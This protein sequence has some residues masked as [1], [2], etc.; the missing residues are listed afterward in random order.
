MPENQ[1]RVLGT[2]SPTGRSDTVRDE[3]SLLPKEISVIQVSVGIRSGTE[4][5]F[6]QVKGVYEQK[7]AELAAKSVDMIHMG[8]AP[9][10]MVHG[11]R[12]EEEFVKG[13]EERYKTPIY[14]AGRSQSAAFRA[15]GIQSFVG[16]T[17]FKESLNQIFANYF[18]QAGFEVQAMEGMDIPFG[19]AVQLSKEEICSF[20]K[21]AFLKH[22]GKADGIYMLGSG[23]KV[24]EVAPVLEAELQVPVVHAQAVKIWSVLKHF[25][26]HRPIA[27]YGRLLKELPE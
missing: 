5:E 19:T 6:R 12:G 21:E 17:Y 26:M 24:M 18:T 27:G 22:A 14:T 2:I 1:K 3:L 4:E 25:R 10:M 8:G 20:A 23:W 16:L 9:P 7:V 15:L 13:L 11:F